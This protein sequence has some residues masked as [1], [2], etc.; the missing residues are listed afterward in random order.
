[1]TFKINW[2]KTDQHFQV[3]L[4]IVKAMVGMA[5]PG[6]DLASHEVVSGGC[7]NLNIKINL[8][9]DSQPFILRIYVRDKT[10]ASIEQKIAV[11]IKQS[12]P[13]PE[14]YFVGD[15]EDHRF[16]ITEFIP[17]ISL[18]ELLL[19]DHPHDVESVMIEAGLILA[20]LRHFEFPVAGFFDGNLI[21]TE[22]LSQENTLTFVNE[23]LKHPTVIEIIGPE[24]I[25]KIESYFDQYMELL[26]DEKTAHLVHGDF[27]PENILVDKI[28]DQ[29]KITAVLDFEFAFAGSTL[30]DVANMLRYAHQVS[31]VFEESFLQG[32]EQGGVTLPEHWRTTVHLLNLLSLLDSL[33]RCPSDKRPNQAADICDLVDCILQKLDEHS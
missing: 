30:F 33:V 17:G 13:T 27:G 9:D 19:G 20:K 29:W 15:Y 23:C 8:K 7:A 3:T 14:V 16:A 12:I 18:R 26:Q 5:L 32:L 10:V 31:P 22:P 24:K 1:M 6:K 4:K 28:N 2:E 11:L 21:V 25:T